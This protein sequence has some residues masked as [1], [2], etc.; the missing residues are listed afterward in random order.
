MNGGAELVQLKVTV[1]LKPGMGVSS[2]PTTTW[3]PGETGRGVFVLPPAGGTM[4][5]VKGTFYAD[6]CECHG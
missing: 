5:K 1:P 2:K 6:A 4:V 3:P